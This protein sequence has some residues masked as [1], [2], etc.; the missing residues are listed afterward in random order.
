MSQP[1]ST[2]DKLNSIIS[3]WETLA[4]DKSFGGMN[5]HSSGL[6]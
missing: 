5:S 2:L 6:R 3:G 1:K 4:P